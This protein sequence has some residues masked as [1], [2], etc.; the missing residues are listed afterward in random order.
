MIS[1]EKHLRDDPESSDAERSICQ[2]I[3]THRA[4]L[5]SLYGNLENI[6][7]GCKDVYRDSIGCLTPLRFSAVAAEILSSESVARELES[8]LAGTM[9]IERYTRLRSAMEAEIYKDK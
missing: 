9:S 2:R 4:N 1:Y 5:A 6:A 7:K 3:D 8:I